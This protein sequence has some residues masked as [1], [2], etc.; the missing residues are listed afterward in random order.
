MDSASHPM[1][2]GELARLDADPDARRLIGESNAIL[3]TPE[4]RAV[5]LGQLA[6]AMGAFARRPLSEHDHRMALER[7]MLANRRGA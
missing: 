7:E 1:P 5:T 2:P 4:E 6:R 3:E